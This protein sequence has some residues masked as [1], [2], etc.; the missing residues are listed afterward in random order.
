M[1]PFKP[2]V[3]TVA[4]PGLLVGV[5][6]VST[7]GGAVSFHEVGLVTTSSAAADPVAQHTVG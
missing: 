3:I 1:F 7:V 6:S 2:R 5:V 4:G